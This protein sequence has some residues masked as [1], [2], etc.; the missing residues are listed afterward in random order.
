ME[1]QIFNW[2]KEIN[3]HRAFKFLYRFNELILR[4]KLN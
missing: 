3:I 2:Y 1:I 4:I